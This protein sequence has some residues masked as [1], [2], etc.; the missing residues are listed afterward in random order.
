MHYA[1]RWR[2]LLAA[3]VDGFVLYIPSAVLITTA[4]LFWG[5]ITANWEEL[6]L[7]G[8]IVQVCADWLYRAVLE[9][10]SQRATFGEQALGIT[11][12]DLDGNQLTFGAASKRNFRKVIS[13]FFI[14]VMILF[15]G[16]GLVGPF[17]MLSAIKSG[18]AEQD[19]E[20]L[21][22]NIDFPTLRRN[23]RE[24]FMAAA[25]KKSG[26]EIEGKPRAGLAAGYASRVDAMLDTNVTPA[27][28]ASLLKFMESRD[29]QLLYDS[30]TT[31]SVRVPSK[32]NGKLRFILKRQGL[33]WRLVNVVIPMDE[34]GK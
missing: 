13:G 17:A 19:M 33:S 22:E 26:T 5:D 23:L 4:A 29:A 9:S 6:L 31:F 12:T 20:K 8:F 2:H 21:S 18:L 15:G 24:Q 10:S 30:P 28:L 7:I 32:K 34:A 25:S 16:Y 11:V 3:T 14:F 1:I 27:G